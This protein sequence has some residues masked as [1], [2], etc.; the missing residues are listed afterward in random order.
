MQ[1]IESVPPWT[2][3]LTNFP[4]V[5]PLAVLVTKRTIAQA[6]ADA[7]IYELHARNQANALKLLHALIRMAK[8]H[9]RDLVLANQMIRIAIE[10]LGI[11]VT[12]QAMQ[13]AGFSDGDLR[14]LQVAL[15][16]LSFAPELARTL[17]MERAKG[18]DWFDSM[19]TG[20]AAAGGPSL[21][22]KGPLQ[23][24][25][26][27]CVLIPLWHNFWLARDEMLF[28]KHTQ[29][30]I[31][32]LRGL[33]NNRPWFLVGTNAELRQRERD[34]GFVKQKFFF[35]SSMLLPAGGV[36]PERRERERDQDA[37]GDDGREQR[38]AEHP[39]EHGGP[40]A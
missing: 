22:S 1:N 11:E 16:E 25:I 17:Q 23:A 40:H 15:D 39:V 28:L 9:D 14:S 37:A 27:R 31:E 32:E 30:V 3:S 21:R 24:L 7:A 38:A 5:P 35:G 13:S 4:G 19:R 29:S 20:N 18:L 6:L 10:G 2:F 33:T 12:W 26:E 8:L 36:Q 34:T